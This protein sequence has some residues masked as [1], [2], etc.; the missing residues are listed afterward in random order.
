MSQHRPTVP[1]VHVVCLGQAVGMRRKIWSSF[2]R[3]SRFEKV[4]LIALP[5]LLAGLVVPAVQGDWEWWE[6]VAIVFVLAVLY[7]IVLRPDF[8]VGKEAYFGVLAMVAGYY[9]LDGDSADQAFY[10]ATAQLIPVVFIALAVE[11]ILAVRS[12]TLQVDRRVSVLL[13]LALINAEYEALRVLAGS[14][15]DHALGLVGGPLVGAAVALLLAA[16]ASMGGAGFVG[17]QS[18]DD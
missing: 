6:S 1:V 7:A 11:A 8:F 4:Q 13:A 15:S 17:R 3:L 18:S 14:G 2:K 5:L 10:E 9:A 16:T 12:K